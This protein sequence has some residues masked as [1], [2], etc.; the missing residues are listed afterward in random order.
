MLLTKIRL[1]GF[2]SF[3]DSAEIKLSTGLTAI[4]GPNG[5]GKSNIVDAVK[6]VLGE[7]RI[8][9][10][11]SGQSKDIIFNGSRS[12]AAAG[13]ASVELLFDNSDGLLK[14]IWGGFSEISVRRTIISDGL[15]TF[16]INGQQVRKKDVQDL[17]AG[18]G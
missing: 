8:S 2:K 12:R 5:C 16:S 13:R 10:L 1:S 15:S 3:V 11:R 14:G 17:F 9:E 18:T 6:W 4:V 7:A